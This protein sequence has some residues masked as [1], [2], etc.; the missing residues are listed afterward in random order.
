MKINVGHSRETNDNHSSIIDE[1]ERD[2][3]LIFGHGK[4]KKLKRMLCSKIYNMFF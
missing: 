1:T 4:Y 3:E 2:T